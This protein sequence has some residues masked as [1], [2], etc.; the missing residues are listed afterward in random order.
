MFRFF[1]GRLALNDWSHVLLDSNITLLGIIH[2]KELLT[3][4]YFS[5]KS[6][7]HSFT[8]SYLVNSCGLSSESAK[9]VSKYV[10]FENPERPD[11]VLSLLKDHGLTKYQISQIVRRVPKLILYDPEKTILPKIQ[12]LRS[13]GVSGPDLPVMISRNPIFLSSSLNNLLVP[14]YDF[15]KSLLFSDEK[16]LIILKR[17]SAFNMCY[18]KEHLPVNL[19]VLRELG[20]RRM[21]QSTISILITSCPNTY[22]DHLRE[23]DAAEYEEITRAP[24][25]SFSLSLRENEAT[26]LGNEEGKV[27]VCDAEMLD[28]LTT[29]RGEFKE[30]FILRELLKKSETNINM[31][32][33]KVKQKKRKDFGAGMG[34]D[35]LNLSFADAFRVIIQMKSKT[36]KRKIDAYS[37]SGLS[38]EEIWSVI[39]KRPLCMGCSEK[40]DFLVNKMGWQPAIV[41]KHPAVLYYSFEKRVVPRC[42]V[43]R[44]LI[45]KGL[46]RAEISLASILGHVC[47]QL[48]VTPT[49]ICLKSGKFSGAVKKVIGMGFDPLNISFA[50]ALR[51]IIQLKSKTLKR[52]VDAYS[53]LGLSEEEI[54]SAFRNFPLFMTLSEKTFTNK[55]DFLV[56]KMGWQ[57]AV[58]IKFPIVLCYS[59]EKR[60]VPRCSIVRVLI[61][62]GL[63]KLDISLK[64]ILQSSE[65]N[66]LDMF[67]SKYQEQVAEFSDVLLEKIEIAE[68]GLSLMKNLGDSA[69]KHNAI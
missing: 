50:G 45:L 47:D 28:E 43:L 17:M 40:I 19:S 38:E 6:N 31:K 12:F 62:K 64:Y 57:P 67:V 66:F 53:R 58:V 7:Q 51:V 32:S 18:V 14:F 23:L 60:I 37:G 56:N 36:W 10:K 69:I 15:L 42:S 4:R 49:F 44:V 26:G 25:L 9:L 3:V 22:A 48:S 34:L 8:V 55:M 20:M 59:L 63:I 35:P 54:F 1:S 16:V 13:V 27:Q 2:F 46:I 68:L 29:S 21:R 30:L 5:S 39:K 11:S 52:K 65:K 61:L 33:E 24:R 41:A